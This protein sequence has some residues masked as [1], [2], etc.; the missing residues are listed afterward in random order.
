MSATHPDKVTISIGQ[1][2][3]IAI[4]AAIPSLFGTYLASRG[5][6]REEDLSRQIAEQ[7]TTIMAEVAATYARR[8]VYDQRI[9]AALELQAERLSRLAD[10]VE[11]V[12]GAVERVETRLTPTS[13]K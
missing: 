4:M 1:K 10:K 6:L 5:T 2:G 9:Q 12:A 3:V 13:Q 8:D 11:R 7:R